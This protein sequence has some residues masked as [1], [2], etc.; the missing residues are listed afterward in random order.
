MHCILKNIFLFSLVFFFIGCDSDPLDIDV[1]DIK[2][3]IKFI[4]IDSI[5]AN[6]SKSHRLKLHNQFSSTIGPLYNRA[7]KDYIKID[8]NTDSSFLSSLDKYYTDPYISQLQ[9]QIKKLG[10]LTKEREDIVNG[11]KHLRYYFPNKEIPKNVVF[12]STYFFD[13][14]PVLKNDIG[15]SLEWYL[16]QNDAVIKQLPPDEFPSYYK[17][18]MNIKFLVRDVLQEWINEKYFNKNNGQFYEKMIYWGKILYLTKAV[19]PS[20]DDA[21]ICRYSASD[22]A[23][24]TKEE[25]NIWKHLVDNEM[26]FKKD[27]L[28]D[29]NWFS[30]GPFTTGLGNDSPQ[31]IGQF[32]GYKMVLSYLE[33][34]VEG[35]SCSQN[36]RISPKELL[37]VPYNDILQSYNINTK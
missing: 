18:E 32:I 20:L 24:S 27:K 3:D 11:F 17:E 29:H 6:P 4:N 16:N 13:K 37:D 28:T 12:L 15:V 5:Y 7:Y 21:M 34:K 30:E 25:K 9:N 10:K 36:K 2:V 33:K 8:F 26:L 22:Y 14:N 23:W 19:L 1:S 35:F 31:R